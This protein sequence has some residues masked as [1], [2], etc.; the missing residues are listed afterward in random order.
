[1]AQTGFQNP[2]KEF[3][4]GPLLRHG[5]HAGSLHPRMLRYG[6]NLVEGEEFFFIPSPGLGLWA[7]R[8]E[9]LERNT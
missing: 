6:Y 4:A 3:A 1:M 9:L 2:T 8:G 5:Q 7:C